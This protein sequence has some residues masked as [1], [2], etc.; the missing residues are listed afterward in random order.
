MTFAESQ[1][2]LDN[3]KGQVSTRRRKMVRGV[4]LNTDELRL[5]AWIDQLSAALVE[6]AA[7]N[8]RDRV[9]L[10]RVLEA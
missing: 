5:D 6:E 7:Q 1:F 3:N 4:A 10:E 2:V 9:A 8:E